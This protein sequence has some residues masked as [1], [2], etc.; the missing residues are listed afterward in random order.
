MKTLQPLENFGRAGNG[1]LLATAALM[2]ADILASSSLTSLLMTE[3]QHK[4][5]SLYDNLTWNVVRNK[6]QRLNSQR[7][8]KDKN[9]SV[10]EIVI[11]EPDINQSGESAVQDTR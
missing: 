1:A 10:F 11:P 4:M 3:K 7:T 6:L 5:R 9:N 2:A 8:A